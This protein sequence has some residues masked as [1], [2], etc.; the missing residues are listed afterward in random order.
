MKTTNIFLAG[1]GG[2]GIILT[3]KILATVAEIS[4]YDVTT[5]E[6]HGMAQRG[7]S[8]TAQIRYGTQVISPLILEG[9]ADIL[10]AS[11]PIEAIRYAHYLKKDG[12][13]VVSSTSLIPVTVSSGQATYP[14]NVEDLLNRHFSHLC[15]K[16]FGA[17]AKVLGDERMS[18][19]LML[20]YVSNVLQ[21]PESTWI[22]ALEANIKP[23]YLE[24][25]ISAFKAG[26]EGGQQ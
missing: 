16:D 4:G 14:A 18:N 26:R 6:I 17:Y 2:Q 1:V 21:I 20:G 24:A 8:V 19:V 12:F 23:A 5:S 3:T 13:A 25:N 22:K 9:T 15:Y 11:E 10:I 7:G